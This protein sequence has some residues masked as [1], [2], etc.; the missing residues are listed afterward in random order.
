MRREVVMPARTENT[1]E[2]TAKKALLILRSGAVGAFA[3]AIDLAAL[4]ALVELGHLAP[5]IASIPALLL[6]VAAQFIGNKWF[7]FGDRS[8][9]LAKQGAQF[10]AVELLAVLLNVFFF[11]RAVAL[12]PIPYVLARVLVQSC[13]Y[14]GISL[15][16]WSRIFSMEQR[17]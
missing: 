15:P 16:L 5:Q 9:D 4:T 8:R 14:F 3:T 10:L 1:R 7:A 13:V 11:D 6:G 17:S 12:T 2:R